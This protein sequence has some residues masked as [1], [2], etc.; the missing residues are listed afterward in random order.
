MIGAR[1]LGLLGLC[2]LVMSVG[3]VPRSPTLVSV[4][5]VGTVQTEVRLGT[6]PFTANV[7]VRGVSVRGIR[8]VIV[9]V[10][11]KAGSHVPAVSATYSRDYLQEKSYLGRRDHL[12]IPVFGLYEDYQNN[13]SIAIET[14]R[15]TFTVTEEILTPKWEPAV[16][17]NYSSPVRLVDRRE[18]I[19]LSYGFMML[20]SYTGNGSPVVVD[21]DGE[22]RWVGASLPSS[23]ASLKWG[24][25][26]F[27]AKGSSL[28][29]Q[30]FNSPSRLVG[31][32]A[33]SDTFHHNLDKGREGLLAEVDRP[34]AYHSIVVEVNKSAGI[35]HEWDV[36]DIVAKV[37]VAG[38]DDPDQFVHPGKDWFHANSAAYWKATN[39]LV[40]SGRHAFV[41]GIDYD[42]GAVKWILGDDRRPWAQFPSL[43]ARALSTTGLA[44]I[45]QHSVGF[46]G[47]GQL[48]LFDN[49]RFSD[50]LVDDPQDV[51]RTYSAARRYS[52]DP[53]AMTATMTWSYD[54]N[55]TVLSRICSSAVAYGSSMLVD[56][57]ADSAGGVRLVGLDKRG[58]TAF[59]YFYPGSW[60]QAW[61]AQPISLA[62][63][64]FGTT[65]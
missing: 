61:A 55:R 53:V 57:A 21:T 35:I 51:L 29:Q 45:G 6:T 19:H 27:V 37:M 43:R 56:F 42:T 39:T 1:L 31:S 26:F 49:G 38:G 58:R 15:G 48:V 3:I 52:I 28:Y 63:L 54:H 59:E 8:R 10:S 41:I 47:A 32:L 16:A 13:V 12:R 18:G 20:K 34:G 44:P 65:R 17:Q 4:E 46:D 33:S 9:T 25:D 24:N 5:R 2:A 40:V 23:S 36:A 11:S 14:T 30:S 50:P 64:R 7:V 22:V 60:M 62:H